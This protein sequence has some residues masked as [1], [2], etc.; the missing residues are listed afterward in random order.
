VEALCHSSQFKGE[1]EDTDFSGIAER[2]SAV[3]IPTVE[4]GNTADVVDNAHSS[5]FGETTKLARSGKQSS[6]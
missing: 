2:T 6:D 1:P 4:I 3:P 5:A